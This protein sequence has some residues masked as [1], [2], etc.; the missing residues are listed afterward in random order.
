MLL[1]LASSVCK[2]G[3]EAGSFFKVVVGYPHNNLF[4]FGSRSRKQH[5]IVSECSLAQRITAW[6][7]LQPHPTVDV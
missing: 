7:T 5:P 6:V 2:D 1:G 4:F 3:A